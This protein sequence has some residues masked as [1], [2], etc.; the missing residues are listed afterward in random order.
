MFAFAKPNAHVNLQGESS[1]SK[2]TIGVWYRLACRSRLCFERWVVEGF[3]GTNA[4]APSRAVQ[5]GP[6][7]FGAML[8][9]VTRAV[10]DLD[11]P[12]RDALAM[13]L[14]STAH[15]FVSRKLSGRIPPGADMKDLDG[16]TLETRFSGLRFQQAFDAPAPPVVFRPTLESF[17]KE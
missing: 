1:F 11:G 16:Q 4:L 14:W 2:A 13:A 17:F 8:T 3:G 7:A 5:H 6:R 10:G 9:A 12:A 15:V